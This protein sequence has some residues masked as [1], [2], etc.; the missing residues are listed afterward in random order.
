MKSKLVAR[1]TMGVGDMPEYSDNGA[2]LNID[3]QACAKI[4]A[5]LFNLHSAIGRFCFSR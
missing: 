5:W 3:L 2:Q 4:I 1:I